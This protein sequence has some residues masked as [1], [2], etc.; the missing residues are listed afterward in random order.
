[1]KNLL[2]LLLA[3]F[4]IATGCDSAE[5][6]KKAG[7]EVVDGAKEA[8]N[9]D[10]KGLTE[11]F[12]AITGGF[13]DLSADNVG[14]LTSKITELTGSLDGMG[15]DKLSGVTKTG[16]MEA[17][18]GFIGKVKEAMGGIKDEGILSKLK[19][20]IEPLMEKLKGFTS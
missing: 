2:C 5:S 17:I 7:K 19:P 4:V 9:F 12:T 13:K 16:A 18:K 15:I 1:M 14:G 3:C 8:A 6:V 20:A 11:K 10:L